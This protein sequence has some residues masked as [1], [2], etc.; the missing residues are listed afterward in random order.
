VL[1][2]YARVLRLLTFG[3]LGLIALQ[4][5]FI[6]RGKDPLQDLEAGAADLPAVEVGGPVVAAEKGSAPPAPADKSSPPAV[7]GGP[8]EKV[9]PAPGPGGAPEKGPP[10]P[11]PGSA[12]PEGGLPEKYRRIASSGIFGAEPSKLVPLTLL[13]LAGSYA[14]IMTPSGQTDLVPEGGE[15]GGVKVLKISTNRALVEYQG[16]KQE[17]T[18]F[19]GLG[20]DSL[21]PSGKE[22][23]P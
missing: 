8:A 20:S 3:L 4:A 10:P 17:L 16:K 5:G 14:I 15:L 22:T 1:E 2:R 13:G 9:P 23:S 18:I 11:G 19:S 7:S 21:L 6:A 12:P